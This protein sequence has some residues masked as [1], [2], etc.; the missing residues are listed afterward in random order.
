[1][2]AG[3]VVAHELNEPFEAILGAYG[4]ER[5]SEPHRRADCAIRH[6]LPRRMRKRHN[7]FGEDAPFDLESLTSTDLLAT[8]LGGRGSS[9]PVLVELISRYS[10][11]SDLQKRLEETH[12]RVPR[13]QVQDQELSREAVGSRPTLRVRRV[14]DRVSS[15]AIRDLIERHQAGATARELATEFKIGATSIKK[16][17]RE[18]RARRRDR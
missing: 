11:R 3:E 7:P 8:A 14:C 10:N 2:D 1:M 13:K 15:E 16:L 9:K 18:H 5:A 17:L 12:N 4:R 6:L